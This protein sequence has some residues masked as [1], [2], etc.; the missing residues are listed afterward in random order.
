MAIYNYSSLVEI[1]EQFK[2]GQET[3]ANVNVVIKDAENELDPLSLLRAYQ[4]E[5]TLETQLDLAAK[6]IMN[7]EVSF[8]RDDREIHHFVYGGG[9][10]AS[11]FKGAPWLL[12][13][14]LG[15]TQGLL[16]KKLTP[17]SE[18]SATVASGLVS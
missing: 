3:L 16:L 2:T 8:V 10:L 6:F 18:D 1:M 13:V 14:L 12:D 11:K 5:R 17:P 15:V 7:K 9:D 4:G